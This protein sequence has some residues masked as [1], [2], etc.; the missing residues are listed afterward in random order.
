MKN[1]LNKTEIQILE[2]CVQTAIKETGGEFGYTEDVKLE[3]LTNNQIKGY[4]SQLVQKEMISINEWDQIK[5]KKQAAEF[6]NV[7][8]IQL[9]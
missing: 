7:I 3:G 1:I 9:V 5:I 6:T 8:T 4:L 2:V